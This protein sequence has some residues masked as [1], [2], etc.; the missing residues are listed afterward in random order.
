MQLYMSCLHSAALKMDDGKS[1]AASVALAIEPL[2][3]KEFENSI[4]IYGQGM[5]PEA[6]AMFENNVQ[7]RQME[8][9]TMAVLD[10]RKGN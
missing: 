6:Q 4:S 10:E 3:A 2:C 1:D 7:G 9:A 5:N 8:L